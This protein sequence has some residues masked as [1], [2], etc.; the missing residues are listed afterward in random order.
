MKMGSFALGI[1]A[2]IALTAVI[3]WT[4]MPS[5]M[6]KEHLSPYG[7]DETVAKIKQNAEAKGWVSPSVSSIHKS[8]KKHGVGDLPPVQLVNLCE[9]HHAYNI[10]KSDENKIVSVM[11]PC[12]V[13]VYEK[14]D[15]KTYIGTMNTDLLGRMFGG[16]IAEIMGQ[17]VS[18]DQQDFIR[19]IN[20]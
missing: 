16:D 15:G 14:S 8:I 11:M 17:Q 9:P 13:S 5:M 12:T 6:L 2:G 4:V 7:V 10:L 1:V 20:D 19:F 18:K 3:G